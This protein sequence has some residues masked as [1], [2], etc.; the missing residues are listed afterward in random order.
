MIIVHGKVFI[1][2]QFHET[3][4]RITGKKIAEIGP[5]LQGEEILDARGALI[6]PGFI[7]THIHGAEQVNCGESV[8][9]MQKICAALPKYGVTSFTPTPIADEIEASQKAVRV[10]RAAKGTPGSDILGIFLYT[11][12]KNRSIPYYAPPTLPTPQHTLALVDQDLSMIFSA[13]IAPELK[14][15]M[16]WI[17]WAVN[18]DVLPIIGFSEGSPEVIHEAVAHGARLTDHFPN[19]FPA[20]DHHDSQGV[21]QC[22]LE[23]NL[24]MQI[25]CDCIHVAPEFIRMMIQCKGLDHLVAISDSSFLLG[26]PEGEYRMGDK[27][28]FLKAGAVR[29][30]HGK[31]VTG[32]H[33]FDENMRTLRRKGFTLEEIGCLC[34]ENAAKIL[35]LKDRGKIEVG[36]R[37]DLVL[38]DTDLHVQKTMIEGQWF[39][40]HD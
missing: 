6:F 33:S 22:L 39:Y 5:H 15:G 1:D 24:A 38:M 30:N 13:L 25:N 4:I 9:A 34:A 2:G 32:A 36:R 29:D 8:A 3:D 16:E 31:L 37:A 21:V 11:G 7:D 28:V 40:Q 19:G 35:N 18:H 27:Q 10:I 14:G 26:C 20:M 17:D 23:E 12:Y